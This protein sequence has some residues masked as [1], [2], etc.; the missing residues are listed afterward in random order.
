MSDQDKPETSYQGIVEPI[1]DQPKNAPL[2]TDEQIQ[3]QIQELVKIADALR[4]LPEPNVED[5][6]VFEDFVKLAQTD[7]EFSVQETLSNVEYDQIFSELDNSTPHIVVPRKAV[8]S[9]QQRLAEI[10]RVIQSKGFVPLNKGVKARLK[11]HKYESFDD[12]VARYSGEPKKS[13]PNPVAVAEAVFQISELSKALLK[14]V[15]EGRT[16]HVSE[17]KTLKQQVIEHLVSAKKKLSSKKDEF[18]WKAV[19]VIGRKLKVVRSYE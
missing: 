2:F 19:S 13:E 7:E 15:E 6:K 9:D 12:Y 4:T 16:F 18:F 5:L 17:R 14:E 10:K 1:L 8:P 11:P 3:E